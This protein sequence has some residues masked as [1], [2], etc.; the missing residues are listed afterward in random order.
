M[1]ILFVFVGVV[2]DVGGPL[3]YLKKCLRLGSVKFY[4]VAHSFMRELQVHGLCWLLLVGEV[5]CAADTEG[6]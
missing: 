6:S 5:W 1:Y 2:D 3:L 4:F